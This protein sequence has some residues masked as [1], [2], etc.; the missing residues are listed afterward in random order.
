MAARKLVLA[1]AFAFALVLGAPLGAGATT[2]DRTI[3]VAQ[4]AIEA[5]LVA[6]INK[7]RSQHGLP[8]V[9]YSAPLAKAAH[10]HSVAMANGGFFTHESLDGTAFW[11]RIA[12]WYPSGGY[13][14]W[15]VGENL[16]WSSPDIAPAEAVRLWLNS[17]AH[18]AV[19]LSK[20]WRQIGIGAVHAKS[21]PNVY[22][23]LDVTIVTADFGFRA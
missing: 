14:R 15:T 10:A 3:L 2:A 20:A 6:E 1:L 8:A 7:V 17:P 19:L 23:G 22:G 5:P 13:R 11:K 4:D 9:G 12:R 16:L 21:A 18:K